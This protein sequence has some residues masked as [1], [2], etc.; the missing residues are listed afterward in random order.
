M[1]FSETRVYVKVKRDYCKLYI[2][3]NNNNN[4]DNKQYNIKENN[5][6]KQL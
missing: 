5:K 2:Y 4:H 1:Y 3:N 6:Y